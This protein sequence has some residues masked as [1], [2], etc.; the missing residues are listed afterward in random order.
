MHA[1]NGSHKLQCFQKQDELSV[2]M[3]KKAPKTMA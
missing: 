2:R 1:K 3:G